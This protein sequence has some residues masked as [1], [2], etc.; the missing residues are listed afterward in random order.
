MMKKLVFLALAF[1]V[2][3]LVT[4]CKKTE[5][6]PEP[7]AEAEAFAWQVDQFADVKILRYQVKGFESLTPTQKELVYY[8]SQAALS[9]RDITFAQGYKHNLVVRKTL[10]AI[11]E[12][13]KGDRSDPQWA[14]FLTYVKRVWFSNGIHHHYAYDKFVPEFSARVF[15]RPG[16]GDRRAFRSRWPRGRPWT[17]C[18]LS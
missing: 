18:W 17:T 1:G 8:L 12:G 16:Q 14:Q 3:F 15:R 10:D 6:Q 11:V 7:Q 5:P 9:G 13:Y 2:A 4:A